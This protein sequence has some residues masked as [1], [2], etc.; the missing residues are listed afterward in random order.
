[1]KWFFECKFVQED[2]D[3]AQFAYKFL[4]LD[5][6]KK[7]QRPDFFVLLS[8]GAITSILKDIVQFK[9]LDRYTTY[10]VELWA[11]HDS[12]HKGTNLT[13]VDPDTGRVTRL[14]HP[15]RD[16]WEDHFAR[17]GAGIAGRTSVGRT[18]LWLLEMNTGNRFRWRA[19]LL[20]F[21]LLD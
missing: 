11:N 13:G 16:R 14:F 10:R 6:L 5:M 3:T 20:R 9:A 19:L 1:M 8:N 4:Q 2:V 21:G 15:R 7:S 12:D 17:E 18:T